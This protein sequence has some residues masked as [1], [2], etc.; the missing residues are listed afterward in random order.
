MKNFAVSTICLFPTDFVCFDFANDES[1]PSSAEQ[2]PISGTFS[3]LITFT[4]KWCVPCSMQSANIL[5]ANRSKCSIVNFN[6]ACH[7][8]KKKNKHHIFHKIDTKPNANIACYWRHVD[9]SDSFVTL[10]NV[11]IMLTRRHVWKMDFIFSTCKR[12]QKNMKRK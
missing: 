1:T 2:S 3:I 9:N 12:G 11:Y 8:A 10:N 4:C 6:L 7:F 5:S